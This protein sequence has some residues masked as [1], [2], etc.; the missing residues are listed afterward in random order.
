MTPT[1]K[2]RAAEALFP[3]L[4]IF[5]EIDGA[6]L[7][8]VTQVASDGV[9]LE[10][11]LH[12]GSRVLGVK[13]IE[14]DDTIDLFLAGEH[15]VVEGVGVDHLQPWSDLVGKQIGWG[16]VIVNQQ[17]YLDGI[18]LSFG[19]VVPELLIAVVASGLQVRKCLP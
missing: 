5:H 19:G 12:V 15:G 18:L 14:Q 4:T 11:R 17:G 16:W 13:A 3:L 8:G 2:L 7:D 10:I 6:R 9:L 1:V